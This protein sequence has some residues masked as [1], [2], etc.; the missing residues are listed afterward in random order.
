M[1]K[2]IVEKKLY[3]LKIARENFVKKYNDRL[4]EE[5]I[6]NLISKFNYVVNELETKDDVDFSI[7]EELR[8]SVNSMMI[9]EFNLI[10]KSKWEGE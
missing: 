8:N 10:Y 7:I 2:D 4:N 1:T 9:D 5:H 6:K 3:Y